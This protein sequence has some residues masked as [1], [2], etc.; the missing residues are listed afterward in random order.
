[1]SKYEVG[2]IVTGCV[3]G[4]ENYGIFVSLNE[5]YSGLIHISEISNKFV[6]DPSNFVEVGETI[7]VKVIE[8][9]EESCH[10]KLSI[11]DIDYRINRRKGKI[12]ETPNGFETL[13]VKLDDWIED[14]Y[15]EIK[16]E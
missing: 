1:M 9:D 3:T 15:E 7:R 12:K 14:K 16:D 8:K 2:K 13:S 5:Y 10:L 4:I 11:K 6:R